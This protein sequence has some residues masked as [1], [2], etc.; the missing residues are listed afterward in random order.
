MDNFLIR[1][2]LL[3]MESKRIQTVLAETEAEVKLNQGDLAY[4]RDRV[5]TALRE[6]LDRL[7]YP[8]LVQGQRKARPVR[9]RR[10]SHCLALEFDF[11][12]GIDLTIGWKIR[13][14]KRN[15]TH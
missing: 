10:S 8:F 7:D 12:S 13:A 15:K 5:L 14:R 2:Q 9:A 3:T 6:H 11:S 4:L 1:R